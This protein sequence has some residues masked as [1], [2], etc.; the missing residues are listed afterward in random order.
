MSVFKNLTLG[1]K[2]VTLIVIVGVLVGINYGY[3]ALFPK[4]AKTAV[5]TTKATG[6]PPLAYD[7]NANAPFRKLPDLD[8]PAD[9]QAPEIRGAVMGWNG[10][11]AANYVVGGQSTSKGSLAE[12]YGL[13]IHLSVQN[14]C[15]E[16]QNQLYAFAQ[17]LH[18]GQAQPTKGVHF[19]NWMADAAA[20]YLA[21]LNAR[22]TKDFGA[23]YRAEI[24]TFTG[25]SFGEDKWMLKP[26]YTKDARGSLTATVI[27][28]GDWNTAITKCQLMGWEANHDLG[29]YDRNKVNF[30]AAPN[31][32]YIEAG[33]MYLSGAK[34]T[35]KIVENGKVT[36][37]D[38]TMPVTGVSSW[39]PVDQQ[40]VQGK[41]GLVT[42]ASTA[43]FSSQMA[44]GIVM[45]KKWCDDNKDLVTKMIQAFGEGGEQIKAHD[46][47]LQF[48][49]KVSELVFKAEGMDAAAWYNAFKSFP[50]TDDDGN[51][52]QIGGSRAF[53]LADAAKYCGVSGGS[54]TYKRVYETFGDISKEAYP[55]VLSSY[56]AYEEAT[57]WTFLRAAYSKAKGEGK[58]GSIS[59]QDFASTSKGEVVGDANY[60]IQFE[61]GSSTIKPESYKTLDKI[62]SQLNIASN[63]F[64]EIAGHTD[65]TGNPDANQTLSE[66]RAES[67]KR[68][69][70]EKYPDLAQSGRTISK[71]YGQTRPLTGSDETT[72]A[73]R[74][75]NRRV[76]IKLYR[77]KHE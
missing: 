13:N 28:D 68:Y 26:K 15:S 6:V 11:A 43:D 60:A 8:E 41:G 29:T 44:C 47:A 72:A 9:V 70:V 55:E 23:E 21:G 49:S 76:E 73:G 16:Q 24:I 71:G 12:Q 63:L 53:S 61:T 34:V 35:L 66:A 46:E 64:V 32:D 77:A 67:V 22:I 69:L 33:K 19:V 54:D 65:N 25:A 50:L 42:V 30:V 27:R 18:D 45:I 58:E 37:K 38:T 74:S 7:K 40:L 3:K 62:V 59:G 57:D 1:G 48:A 39:F 5:V 56:P 75:Q 17:A 20:N 36:D 4:K 31:D 10:F 52:V 2:I 51:T 14:S